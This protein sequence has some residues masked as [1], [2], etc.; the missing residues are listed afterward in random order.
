MC[1]S[2]SRLETT[3]SWRQYSGRWL[4]SF[5][6]LI[7]QCAS[8]VRRLPSSGGNAEKHTDACCWA[9]YGRL[10]FEHD[11]VESCNRHHKGRC[12]LPMGVHV[13]GN[14][15]CWWP[16]KYHAGKEALHAS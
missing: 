13:F 3:C 7:L 14:H 4:C 1:I 2:C 8:D 12:L 10:C 15:G 16:C 11:C 5:G 6:M 9:E